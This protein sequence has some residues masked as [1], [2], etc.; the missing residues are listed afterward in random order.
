MTRRA[1]MP[2]TTGTRSV[3]TVD[4]STT[5]RGGSIMGQ[6]SPTR[7]KFNDLLRQTGQSV[8]SRRAAPSSG[9][10]SSVP[11]SSKPAG[12][13]ASNSNERT[14]AAPSIARNG[15]GSAPSAF[16]QI[17]TNGADLAKAAT[18]KKSPALPNICSTRAANN[19]A[20]AIAP[21]LISGK[22]AA[23]A[24][25]PVVNGSG[26]SGDRARPP[27]V[28]AIG[29]EPANARKGS[30]MAAAG[31]GALRPTPTSSAPSSA[32]S[33]APNSAP[34]S[35]RNSARGVER[36]VAGGRQ[37]V[38]RRSKTGDEPPAA[39]TPTMQVAQ[40][41][42]AAPAAAKPGQG[43]PPRPRL[44]A[45]AAIAQQARRAAAAAAVA[46]PSEPAAAR[47]PLGNVAMRN[48]LAQESR[49]A[50]A[51]LPADLQR[52]IDRGIENDLLQLAQRESRAL[53][54]HNDRARPQPTTETPPNCYYD[55]EDELL[56]QA[57]QASMEDF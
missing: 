46:P 49:N 13:V 53:A 34:N 41:A 23:A 51:R 29:K 38:R 4:E 57:L 22:T 20:A 33:S 32:R 1:A 21:L 50:P 15:S 55:E 3:L 2:I 36:P 9:H 10:G 19:S 28:P 39:S 7:P 14:V 24:A 17:C 42:P 16:A 44:A 8:V 47:A 56:A 37:V 52:E 6:V 43:A 35:A 31:A 25:A 11:M 18:N 30:G 40:A 45:G 26:G 27:P 5:L 54:N 48:F 12:V